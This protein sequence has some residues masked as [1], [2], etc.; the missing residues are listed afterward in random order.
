LPR[1]AQAHQVG[2]LLQGAVRRTEAGAALSLPLHPP[3][4]H[5]EPPPH[6]SRR[7][8]RRVPLEGSSH[9]RSGPLEDNAVASARVHPALPPARAAQG[10][11]PH[12]PYVDGLLAS[13]FDALIAWSAAVICP[14]CWCG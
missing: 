3:G 8:R 11:P 14:A 5:L 9:R 7:R 10:L 1:P 4:R 13:G 2:G 6:G 12:P